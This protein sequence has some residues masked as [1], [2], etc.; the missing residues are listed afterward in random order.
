[1]ANYTV[2]FTNYT[3]G[4]QVYRKIPQICGKAGQRA[5][6]IGGRQALKAV[7]KKIEAA[8]NG[9]GLEIVGIQWYGGECT[10]KNM[11]RL[12][13]LAKEAKADMIIGIGG[14][15]ALDTAK[16]AAHQLGVPAFTVPTIAATCAAVT[17]LSVVYGEDGAFENF[18]FLDRPPHHCFIDAQVIADAPDRYLR[19]G[20]GDALAKH[21]ECRLASRGS[22]LNYSSAMA[23]EISSMCVKPIL[24]HGSKA[25]ESA[26]HSKVSPELEQVILAN[27]ISTGM[28]SLLVD[29]NYNGAVAHSLFYG[30]TELPHFEEKNLHGDAVA[31]GVLVQLALDGQRTELRELYSFI[32][33]LGM[34]VC[35]GDLGVPND[36]RVLEPALREAVISPDM[37]YLPYKVTKDMIFEAVQLLEGYKETNAMTQ[38]E[39]L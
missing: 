32:K 10:Q 5:L 12:S 7:Q 18:V 14:G 31:Y 4:D 36:R 29:E 24:E 33:S 13:Q 1:M 26:R 9:S 6:L 27:I 20:I 37:E 34:P 17:S 25:M 22:E 2:T 38:Q 11:R 16:A 3:I 21:Y 15:K 19:A 30:L 39:E 35:L 23:V 28:V 8:V